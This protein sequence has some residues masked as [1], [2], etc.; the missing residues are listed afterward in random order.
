[1]TDQRDD[2]LEAL[3]A[4]ARQEAAAPPDDLVARILA[5]ADT[6]ATAREAPATPPRFWP[7]LLDGLGGWPSLAGLAAAAV[8]GLWIGSAGS[9]DSLGWD[10]LGVGYDF[11]ELSPVNG[12]SLIEG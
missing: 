9:L 2:M 6:E 7:S 4:Q 1:M 3:F 11:S 12:V 10:L 8:T 5:D